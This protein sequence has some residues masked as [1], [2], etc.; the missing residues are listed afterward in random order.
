MRQA[1]NIVPFSVFSDGGTELF[2]GPT[3]ALEFWNARN[4][5]LGDILRQLRSPAIVKVLKVLEIT[6]S[7][8]WTA[9][10]QLIV[11]LEEAH[12][13]AQDNCKYLEPLRP[14]FTALLQ[15]EFEA[16]SEHFRPIMHVLLLVWKH[17]K[18][19][20]TPPALALLLRM[21]CN[22]VIDK[23]REYLGGTAELFGAE[24]KE[25]VEKI[26]V[27]LKVCR[28]LKADYYYYYGLSKTSAGDPANPWIKDR[29]RQSDSSMFARLDAFV[30]R[31]EDLLHLCR[32]AQQ[33]EKLATVVIGGNAGGSL[34]SDT[35]AIAQQFDKALNAMKE[36]QYDVLD[37]SIGRFEADI[38]AFSSA[39]KELETR[40]AKVLSLGFEDCGTVFSGFKLVDSFGDL[41]ERDF[42]QADLESKHLELI[43]IFA[44]ELKSVQELFNR[45][46]DGAASVGKFFERDGPPLYVNMPPVSGALAWVQGL[47]RRLTDPMKS[48]GQV[49]AL[50]ED[51]DEVKDVQR[52]YESIRTVL[53]EYEDA[54]FAKWV[55]TVDATLD[56]KLTLPLLTREPSTS[57]IAVNFDPQLTRLLNE[58]KYF[59]LQKKAIPAIAQALYDSA[60]LYRVQTANLTLVRNQY[61]EM[62]RIMLDVEKPLLRG[63]MKAIDKTLDRGLHELVW[64]SAD[65]DKDA[66]IAEAQG[67]V[68]DAYRTLHAM[69]ANMREI[70]AILAKWVG[71]PL[72]TRQSIGKTYNL[73]AYMDE[74]AKYL[75]ARQKDI[76]D[77]GKEIHAYLKASNEVLKVSK[78]A[79]A[80]RAYVEYVNTSLIGGIADTVVASLGHLLSQMDPRAIAEA[81]KSPFF[82]VKLELSPTGKGDDAVYFS[83]PLDGPLGQPSVTGYVQAIISDFYNVVK[84]VKRLDRAE[85]DFLKEMEENESV[86]FHVH[87]IAD[88]LEAN[89]KMAKEQRQPFITHRALWARDIERTLEEFLDEALESLSEEE[90]AN[91]PDARGMPVLATFAERIGELKDE[92]AEIKEL[93][94]VVT[95]G[96]LRIDAK[97]TKTALSTLAAKWSDA[98]TSYL[99]THV[100]RELDELQ[101]FITSVKEGLAHEVEENDQPGL[102]AAM[103]HVRDVRVKQDR[104]DN[105]FEPLKATI[106]LLKKFGISMGEEVNE[107]LE[108]LPFTWDDTKKIQLNAREMLGPLQS[109]QQEKVK[110]ETEDFRLRVADFVKVRLRLQGWG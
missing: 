74:H 97:P 9:F 3:V 54:M 25:A 60:E 79:P 18:Y 90:L 65:A 48:L 84:F 23:S 73:L 67:L 21:L 6:R 4:V 44:D 69:K 57:E 89:N 5:D 105:L 101:A 108:M 1:L 58:C 40:I 49:L 52:M 100:H 50:M 16:V 33:F 93:E 35:E 78:G 91:S 106:S 37:V 34:T 82:D 29:G 47:L 99:A 2:P 30:Q 39:V 63:A 92:E 77:G 10:T 71:A 43:R 45:E 102:I 51:T 95:Q 17:S 24:P 14:H 15:S 31:C 26:G 56:E 110:E 72:I 107:T 83:P 70:E 109:M 8:Y 88:E 28:Q 68:D 96:W 42:V 20:N 104:I 66:F 75:E 41:L 64:R 61:N 87:R 22:D 55:G 13:Q 12:A 85:G 7:P 81:G 62:L 27:V 103:E 32:T 46:R 86:R 76:T 38:T 59:V 94:S 98:H 53:C 80:W 11:R 36:L 19:Y